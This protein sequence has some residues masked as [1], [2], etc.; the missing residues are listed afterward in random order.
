MKIKP[1]HYTYIKGAIAAI[2][3]QRIKDHR[4]FI[5]AEGKAKDVEK[6]VRWDATYAAKLSQWLGDNV[7]PYANDDHIDTALRKVFSELRLG[8]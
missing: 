8:A 4:T 3:P 2:D 7:Y 5:I 6:R 1:E